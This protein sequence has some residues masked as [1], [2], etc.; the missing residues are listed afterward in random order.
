MA[1]IDHDAMRS[2]PGRGMRRWA[3]R[4]VP[5]PG[6]GALAGTAR[7]PRFAAL[8]LALAREL[9]GSLPVTDV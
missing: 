5:E 8:A 3:G 6:R 7:V 9:A 2:A 1:S 4:G